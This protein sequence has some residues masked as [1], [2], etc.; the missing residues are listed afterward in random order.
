M[1][2]AFDI[3]DTKIA[4]A[5]IPA[6][7]KNAIKAE[8][9]RIKILD[10]AAGT[11]AQ[12]GYDGASM[13][14]I[15]QGA[16][17]TQSLL[18]HHFQ[19]KQGLFQSVVAIHAESV[20]KDRLEFAQ[21]YLDGDSE[22]D[23]EDLVRALVQPWIDAVTDPAPNWQDFTRFIIN[24]GYSDADWSQDIAVTYY[25]QVSK[26]ITKAVRKAI[27]EFS[28]K[29]AIWAYFLTISMFFMFLASPRRLHKVS[30]GTIPLNNT[31]EL[32]NYGI[33]YAIAGMEALREK[34]KSKKPRKPRKTKG[35]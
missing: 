20:N 2:R 7:N 15:A 35:K 33:Q 9:S 19:S 16:G 4:S 28:D 26:T 3:T 11:F 12:Y 5:T 6:E 18:H 30:K 34:A 25:S 29:E 27:P 31:K 21:H 1:K 8:Q 24:S 22:M 17:V 10:A 23:L 14:L 13:R 32:E